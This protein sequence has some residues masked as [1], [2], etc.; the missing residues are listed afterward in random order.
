MKVNSQV[1]DW[2]IICNMRST[3]LQ[4]QYLCS[5]ISEQVEQQANRFDS[6]QKDRLLQLEQLYAKNKE[7]SVRNFKIILIAKLEDLLAHYVNVDEQIWGMLTKFSSTVAYMEQEMARDVCKLYL[8]SNVMLDI[9][10]CQSHLL[11]LHQRLQL[12]V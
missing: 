11:H 10:K 6:I 3:L 9:G 2:H 7:M 12:F 8:G 4:L 1:E 5:S